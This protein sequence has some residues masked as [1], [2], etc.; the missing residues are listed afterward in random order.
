MAIFPNDHSTTSPHPTE[1][2]QFAK[3]PEPSM[4]FS[5]GRGFSITLV[6][7]QSLVHR[8]KMSVDINIFPR[9]RISQSRVGDSDSLKIRSREED[10]NEL[11]SVKHET[12]ARV[13]DAPGDVWYAHYNRVITNHRV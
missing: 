13:H 6:R 10:G 5:Q 9:P 11:K 2:I 12:E 4:Y 3:P 1:G 8:N 7:G